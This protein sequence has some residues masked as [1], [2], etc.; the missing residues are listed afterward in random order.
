MSNDP[1]F[2]HRNIMNAAAAAAV[3]PS[4]SPLAPRPSRTW[5]A[6]EDGIV[7]RTVLAD[8]A[9]AVPFTRWSELASHLPGRTGKQA[10]DR[11]TNY[12]NPAIDRTPFGREDDVALFKGH[13][14]FG[15]RWVEISES[16][17][18]SRRSENQV[19]NR[20]RD[21]ICPFTFAASAYLT[22]RSASAREIS[23]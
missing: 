19:K 7:W 4:P 14:E 12:L 11:W 1:P 22:A 6:E 5:T 8:P 17:F 2:P 15:K 20:V 23:P 13:G 9:D 21:G 16:V 3:T 10:R 18:H